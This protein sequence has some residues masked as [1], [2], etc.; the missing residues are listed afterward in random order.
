MYKVG[1]SKDTHNLIPG[2]GIKIGGIFIDCNVKVESYSD[3]D[4]LFHALSESIHGAL[5]LEDLGFYYNESNMTKGFDSVIILNSAMNF[6]KNENY[7]ISNVDILIELD[8]PNLKSIKTLIK[9]NLHKILCI[10]ERNISIKATTSEGNNTSIIKCY[11]T[12][13]I[14]KKGKENE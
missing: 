4:V 10:D 7:F 12:I 11:S 2:E 6:L 13:L 9:N 5:G 3:G 1:F 8:S 14:Y